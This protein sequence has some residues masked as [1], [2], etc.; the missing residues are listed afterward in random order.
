MAREHQGIV[1]RELDTL[2]QTGTLSGATD[3]TLLDHYLS[4]APDLAEAAFT[5]LV[6]R[7][8]PMVHR[9]CLGVLRIN[10]DAED[11]AQATFLALLKCAPQV[12]KRESIASWLHGTA[13]RIASCLRRTQQRKERLEA[14]AVPRIWSEID[15]PID[16]DAV[17]T[18]HQEIGKLPDAYRTALVL[19]DLEGYSYE[20]AAARVSRPVGT[21]KSRVSRARE[22]LR[23]KL[24]RRGLGPAVGLSAVLAEGDASASLLLNWARVTYRIA[25]SEGLAGEVTRI[26]ALTRLYQRSLLMAYVK[27]GIA[28]LAVLGV[29][30]AGASLW[31]QQGGGG[32]FGGG[33]GGAPA[34]AGALPDAKSDV[35][36]KTYAVPDLITSTPL[37][38]GAGGTVDMQPIIE[39]IKT[40]VAPT[41]WTEAPQTGTAGDINSALNTLIA[42]A[43][44]GQIT[45]VPPAMS[46]VIR[47]TPEVHTQIAN[48]LTQL[49]RLVEA[50]DKQ[51]ASARP[52]GGMTMSSG[53][54]GN[55]M[56]GGGGG[57]PGMM[58]MMGRAPGNP[59]DEEV[60]ETRPGKR[61]DDARSNQAQGA[62]GRMG[63]GSMSGMMGMMM[64]AGGGSGAPSADAPATRP[65]KPSDDA[66]P[67]EGGMGMSRGSSSGRQLGDAMK[68]SR[69]PRNSA[70]SQPGD[71]PRGGGSADAAPGMSMPGGPAMMGPSSAG[72]PPGASGGG[73]GFGGAMND[74]MMPGMP[75]GAMGGSRSS[76]RAGSSS[77]GMQPGGNSA[78]GNPGAMRPDAAP[79][80]TDTTSELE[81]T[82]R[83]LQSLE[84]KLDR[85]INAL[86][87]NEKAPSADSAT[88]R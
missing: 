72:M 20:E 71:A 53:G 34:G 16:A 17:A 24:V 28:A 35:V 45:A 56:M 43:R 6:L 67:A 65:G 4:E 82:K 52:R 60:M 61:S 12:R 46:L 76:S 22:Q 77:G 36:V 55:M 80:N 27:N 86:E 79:R 7:H 32:G 26:L 9:V 33:L 44:V 49:R 70:D 50:R 69:S 75:P 73:G 59:P 8:G 81:D 21:V 63:S 64:G 3:G 31:A 30:A 11:A 14:K 42:N 40:T 39:L 85:L 83:R 37:P 10:H 15:E 87:K 57:M 18:I 13:L 48:R 2:F 68:K 23:A 88:R 84:Q 38:D 25:A 78:M 19:C 58:G 1:L 66:R 47:Q 74:M 62:A 54:G 29:F 5:V 51:I 41:T